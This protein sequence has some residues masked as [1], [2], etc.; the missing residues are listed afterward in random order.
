MSQSEQSTTPVPAALSAGVP[1]SSGDPFRTLGII[2]FVLSFF[3]FV[4]VVALII[5]IIAFVRSRRAG[6]SNRFALAGTV[7]SSIGVLVT[8]LVA[9][10]GIS[11]LVGA[12]QTCGRLGEG[13]HRVGSST[14]TCTRTS[15]F[16][17]WGS[18][19]PVPSAGDQQWSA[20]S[21][22]YA[23]AVCPT[24]AAREEV[25]EAIETNDIAQIA[26]L[27]ASASAAFADAADIFL[28]NSW[29]P[30]I[31][32][33]IRLLGETSR[34]LAGSWEAVSASSDMNAAN[35]VA[36][37]DAQTSFEASQRVRATLSQNGQEP[38][39]C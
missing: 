32:E 39:D 12:A 24:N 18:E 8:V 36:F 5:S 7:I 2:G 37:P 22:L 19:E 30:E 13:I 28:D 17:S 9:S 11:T 16:V 15:F 34:E 21:S 10:F 27:A 4:N 1:R 38:P 33:D 6:F 20:A 3:A 26:P 23:E 14:Y 35:A 25:Y 31:G 29:P